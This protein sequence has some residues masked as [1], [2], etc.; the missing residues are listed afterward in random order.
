MKKPIW[1]LILLFLWGCGPKEQKSE[2]PSKVAVGKDAENPP[3]K[4]APPISP[5][6]EKSKVIQVGP[7]VYLDLEGDK[8]TVVVSSKVV[9]RE[10]LL[11]LLLCRE[12]TKE[13][14]S[15]LAAPVDA[16][17]MHQAMLTA[18]L[19]PGTPVQFMPD[20]KPATGLP[21]DIKLRYKDA[22]GKDKIVPA[23][24]WIKKSMTNDPLEAAWVFA[25]S[26]LVSNSIDPKAPPYFLANDGDLISI[27]NF[28][29]ALIDVSIKITSANADLGYEPMTE[30]IPKVGTPVAILISPATQIP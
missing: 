24:E 10:G 17:D 23:R 13:H 1:M 5:V 11:E 19:K 30:K 7:G 3:V 21:L 15:I 22:T 14:E 20:Y 26:R 6:S 12:K 29:S 8:R 27:S 16:R 25:G 18:G 4:T 2:V 28:E 9:R